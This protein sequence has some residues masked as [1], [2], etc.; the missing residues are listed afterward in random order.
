MNSPAELGDIVYLRDLRYPSF[1]LT[2]L[3]RGGLIVIAE[4]DTIAIFLGK[5]GSFS[6]KVLL[7]YGVECVSINEVHKT[8]L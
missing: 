3:K 4:P 8:P 7:S 2:R 5:I 6:C 1:A